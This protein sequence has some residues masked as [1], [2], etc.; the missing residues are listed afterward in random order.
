MYKYILLIFAILSIS[1]AFSCYQESAN[2]TN[3][4]GID[5][6]CGQVYNGTY[7]FTGL[8]INAPPAFAYTNTVDGDYSTRSA[9]SGIGTAIIDINYTKPS[10]ANSSSQWQVKMNRQG[11]ISTQNYSIPTDCWAQNPLQLRIQVATGL[12]NSTY[13]ACQNGSGYQNISIYESLVASELFEEGMFW[14]VGCGTINQGGNYIFTGNLSTT[15]TCIS[16]SASNI[17]LNCNSNGINT[18]STTATHNIIAVGANNNVTIRNCFLGH[19][20]SRAIQLTSSTNVSILNNQFYYTGNDEGTIDSIYSTSPSDLL[21][22]NNTHLNRAIRFMFASGASNVQ[23]YNNSL[24][25]VFK[26]NMIVASGN[27]FNVISNNVTNSGNSTIGS[28]CG[29]PFNTGA[30]IQ[31]VS[32]STLTNLTFNFNILNNFS[33][34]GNTISG[35]TVL[36]NTQ[37]G[38]RTN[39]IDGSGNIFSTNR[40]QNSN[41]TILQISNTNNQFYN[42]YFSSTTGPIQF[43]GAVANIWNVTR[44]TSTNIIGGP[45]IGGNYYSSYTGYD[46]DNDGI[47]D[48]QYNLSSVNIDYLPLT[49]DNSGCGGGGGGGGG[50]QPQQPS[51]PPPTTPTTSEQSS[52]SLPQSL[53]ELGQQVISNPTIPVIANSV[54]QFAPNII[55]STFKT[56]SVRKTGP[57]EI[58]RCEYEGILGLVFFDFISLGIIVS[59]MFFVLFTIFIF[60]TAFTRKIG[61]KLTFGFIGGTFGFMAIVSIILTLL[62]NALIVFITKSL[63]GGI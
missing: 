42:N 23:F 55:T 32:A 37:N 47:G 43:I 22:Q 41:T 1:T 7:D 40:F 59:L 45:T 21:V 52:T 31:E 51:E 58:F 18:T 35:A 15:S 63:S 3:Q 50:G 33:M 54:E 29:A 9:T 46:C 4:S 26:C 49:N 6:A 12:A 14:E 19:S 38:F 44:I 8:W 5:G 36:G 13:I 60:G 39:I 10:L 30:L 34:I 16:I 28:L 2:T 25:G 48:T 62:N 53:G 20:A 57:L 27:N 17:D 61:P 24:A 11:I 56:C